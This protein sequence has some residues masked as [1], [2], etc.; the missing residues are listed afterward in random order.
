MITN[1]NYVDICDVE[2]EE[3]VL[4]TV[5]AECGAVV[6][7]GMVEI[8]VALAMSDYEKDGEYFKVLYQ[9]TTCAAF[10]QSDAIRLINF[11]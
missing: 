11:R 4:T 5:C 10:A 6:D 7:T 9:C 1:T 3:V 8:G 2:I